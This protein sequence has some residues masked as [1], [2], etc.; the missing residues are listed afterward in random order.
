MQM[1]RSWITVM[2][3]VQ[4]V[5]YVF[6]AVWHGLLRPGAEP[7]TFNEM[8]RH[9]ATVHLPLYIGALGVL[10]ATGIA[11][12]RRRVRP[13][14]AARALL[15]AFGGALLSVAAE[16]WHAYSHLQMDT[17]TGPIAG[18]VSFVGFVIAAAAVLF[19][20]RQRRRRAQALVNRRRA[21]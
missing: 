12:S 21:A 16:A 17:H 7:E 4:L 6:D 1:A 11:L 19:W 15:I 8:V 9:L 20:G 5:G 10:I 2:L 18:T 14:D 3:V 13:A